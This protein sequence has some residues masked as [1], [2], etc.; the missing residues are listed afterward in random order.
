MSGLEQ[1]IRKALENADREDA[2][3]RARIYQSARQ[4]LEGGLAKQNV[5]DPKVIA[6]QRRRLDD[7]ITTIEREEAEAARQAR[8]A[9]K[10]R[11][12]V[13]DDP[14][15]VGKVP[16]KP[17][18]DGPT[19]DTPTIDGPT[20]D[21]PVLDDDDGLIATGPG[22]DFVVLPELSSADPDMRGFTETGFAPEPERQSPGLADDAFA[23]DAIETGHLSSRRGAFDDI[24]VDDDARA[25]AGHAIRSEPRKAK[26]PKKGRKAKAAPGEKP[27][28][29]GVFATLF[30]IL[31]LMAFL[32]FG[33]WWVLRSDFT[34]DPESRDTAVPNPPVRIEAED[35]EGSSTWTPIFTPGSAAGLTAGSAAN[36]QNV[37]LDGVPAVTLTST[38]TG[39]AGAATVT[40]PPAVIE[41][42][43]SGPVLIEATVLAPEGGGQPVGIYCADG[44]IDGCQRHRFTAPAHREDFVI[45]LTPNGGDLPTRLMISGDLNGG[46]EPLD[47]FAIR[48][49]A[50]N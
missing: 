38:A 16:D 27:K 18:P 23:A 24:T 11:P 35:F 33:V 40:L 20:L 2:N 31:I 9:R 47:I 1:A 42:L 34:L 25:P 15:A 29:R 7:I 37:T 30:M 26:T 28:R 50:A 39:D 4:A 44:T 6:R 32:L 46:G 19:I 48:A 13:F 12:P 5:T 41:L 14:F 36:L 8:E 17:T 22:A 43:Q 21:E 3:Q 49:S 45:R 10:P